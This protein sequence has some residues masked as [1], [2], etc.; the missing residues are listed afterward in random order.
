MRLSSFQPRSLWQ[1]GRDPLPARHL[2]HSHFTTFRRMDSNPSLASVQTL[3]NCPICGSGRLHYLFSVALS[4]VVRCD[5]CQLM[6]RNP[7]DLAA[8]ATAGSAADTPGIDQT[9]KAREYLDLLTRYRGL[10]GGRLLAVARGARE[11][12]AQA[13]SRGYEVS[14]MDDTEFQRTGLTGSFEVV[15]LYNVLDAAPDPGG[16][17][18][19]IGAML[20]PGGVLL[21]TSFSFDAWLSQR[22]RHRWT[23]FHTDQLFYFTRATLETLLVQSGF[24]QIIA[25]SDVH[26]PVGGTVG[27][28]AFLARVQPQRARQKLSLVV[29]AFNEARTF[30]ANFSKLLAKE[31]AGLDIEIIVVESNS[32]DG[33]RAIVERYRSHPRVTVIWEDS[34]RGKGHAV[35]GGLEHITGDYVLIQDADLEYDL[36]DYEALLE[37]LVQGRTAFVLGARHGGSA[38]KMRSFAG[39]P[40]ISAVL[41]GAHWFFTML[42]NVGFSARLKDPFTMYKVFRRDCLYGLEFVCN[43]FDFDFELVIKLLRKGYYPLEIPV[44]YR[45]RSFA[46]GKKVSFFGDPLTWLRALV[47]FRLEPMD[48]LDNIVRQRQLRAETGASTELSSYG[49]PGS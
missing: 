45:S 27:G 31:V 11:F 38:W 9:A 15:V 33:T 5:D 20:A 4:R 43:R 10:S 35:R 25:R 19:Q 16:L 39:Q 29:P 44:N 24:G 7:R 37:P 17:L 40:V 49:G 1:P 32:T 21:V 8:L 12:L 26:N 3:A 13:A 30:E 47:R 18:R 48:P 28:M 41:N 46:E 2:I 42:V 23:E 36:E 14:A 6:L 22:S 34:P